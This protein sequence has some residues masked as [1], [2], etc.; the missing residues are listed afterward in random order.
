MGRDD[1][2]AHDGSAGPAHPLSARERSILELSCAGHSV[3]QVA[4]ELGL[5]Q[6]SVK[7]RRRQ[8]YQKLGVRSLTAA[9]AMVQR[10]NL[11]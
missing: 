10:G 9:C 7:N 1:L 4:M 11:E 6:G 8:I 5:S 2:G 3:S